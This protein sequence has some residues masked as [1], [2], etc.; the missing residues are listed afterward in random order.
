[1]GNQ[2]VGGASQKLGEDVWRKAIVVWS[3]LQ[4]K[5]QEKP[6]ALE[7]VMDVA[8]DLEDEDSQATLRKQLKKI[9]E[10]DAVPIF[11]NCENFRVIGNTTNK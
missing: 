11:G 6:A 3:Q 7:A 4:Q 2:V 10:S 8:R 9:L 1:M 5:V